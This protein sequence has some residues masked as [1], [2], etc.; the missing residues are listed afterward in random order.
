MLTR[1]ALLPFS[2]LQARRL[3][4]T[5]YWQLVPAPG[6]PDW[7]A[8]ARKP[9]P[10]SCCAPGLGGHWRRN[11]APRGG[12]SQREK[13]ERERGEGEGRQRRLRKAGAEGAGSLCSLRP[14][15]TSGPSDPG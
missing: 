2:A 1:S 7:L 14:L 15:A 13:K 6:R 11:W 5:F 4:R 8:W 12:A 10:I 3:P 9:A